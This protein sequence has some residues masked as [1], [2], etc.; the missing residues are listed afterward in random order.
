MRGVYLQMVLILSSNHFPLLSTQRLPLV[1][2]NV[3]KKE[4]VSVQLVVLV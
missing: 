1:F 3:N 2:L 4:E